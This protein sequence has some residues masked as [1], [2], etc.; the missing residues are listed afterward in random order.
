M[1]SDL[2]LIQ[3]AHVILTDPKESDT[4]KESARVSLRDLETMTDVAWDDRVHKFGQAIHAKT[5]NYVAM[6]SETAEGYITAVSIEGRDFGTYD[7]DELIPTSLTYDMLLLESP[8]EKPHKSIDFAP[9]G[10]IVSCKGRLYV[11]R[12]G[13]RWSLESDPRTYVSSAQLI[14]AKVHKWGC[15]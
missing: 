3:G 2:D 9:A 11:R 5:G 8:A 12:Y 4:N 13:N 1:N 14:G 10:T 7:R 6:V 15:D